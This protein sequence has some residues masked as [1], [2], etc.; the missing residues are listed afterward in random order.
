MICAKGIESFIKRPFL[1]LYFTRQKSLVL[2]MAHLPFSR[3]N[4]HNILCITTW[5][6]VAHGVRV[7]RVKISTIKHITFS[8]LVIKSSLV[9]SS[10]RS[11]VP[12]F[13]LRSY[14][15]RMPPVAC[16]SFVRRIVFFHKM[17]GLVFESVVW[18]VIGKTYFA[19]SLT[20][21]S[22]N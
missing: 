5:T 10:I 13:G 11:V 18:L 16:L 1:L 7:A 2:C 20:S 9:D 12:V 8:S 15:L 3:N 21:L 14:S 4:L 6:L 22:T 17:A 19:L